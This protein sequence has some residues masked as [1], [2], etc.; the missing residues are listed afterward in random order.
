MPDEAEEE[1]ELDGLSGRERAAAFLLSLDSDTAALVMRSMGDSQVSMLTEAMTRMGDLS[2]QMMDKVLSEFEHQTET[3]AIEPML[4][5]LLEK[6]LGPDKARSLL[7]RIRRKHRDLEPFRSL[8]RLNSTQLEM[9]LRGEHPQVI[10]LVI[11]YLESQAAYELLKNMEDGLRYEVVRRIAATD[12]MPFEMVRQVDAIL[13]ARAM[14]IAS[15]ASFSSDRNRFQIIAQMLNIAEPGMSKSVLE[16]LGAD[17][18]T[19]AQEIQ[20]LMFVFE[21]LVQ[22][23]DRDMQK[24]LSELDRADMALALK[25]ASPEVSKKLLDNLSKRARDAIEEEIEM[26]GP[27]PLQEVEDAQKR[28]IEVVRGLEESGDIQISRG[29]EEM[30]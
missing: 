28:I 1:N 9:V 14:E 22:I 27:K 29:G 12:E 18:P 4:E 24:V 2:G 5:S 30:V 10:G 7:E 8:R 15:Q 26:L 20:A 23:G 11:S 25:T 16:K 3:I 19:A 21:D 13:E 17:L 6:A